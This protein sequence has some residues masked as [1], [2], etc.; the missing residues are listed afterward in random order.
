MAG[1]STSKHKPASTSSKNVAKGSKPAA[2][3]KS[4]T[5]A[6]GTN[7]SSSQTKSNP[8]RASRSASSSNKT[9]A[10]KSSA[11]RDQSNAGL[12]TD[13]KLDIL[14]VSMALAGILTLLS[15]LS[16][17]NGALT[18][19]WVKIIGQGFGWGM[20]VLP[21]GLLVA[22]VWLV[23][24]KFERIPRIGFERIIGIVLLFIVLLASIHF[25]QELLAKTASLE[26]ASQGTGGGYLGGVI[27]WSLQAALGKGGA[28]IAL[29]ALILI[30][31]AFTLEISVYEMGDWLGKVLEFVTITGPRVHDERDQ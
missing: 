3:T 22:G 25:S 14:G 5:K 8:S 10:R 15:L 4:G 2:K 1:S 9:S 27:S 21:I 18:G 31:L 30:A 7:S 24:R 12:S 28:F 26:L 19:T 17:V 16:P 29:L 6:K 20:Y 23:L 13:R 11:S